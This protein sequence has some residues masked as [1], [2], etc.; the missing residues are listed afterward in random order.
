M[1]SACQTNTLKIRPMFRSRLIACLLL[2]VGFA[3]NAQPGEQLVKVV[4]APDHAD[5]TYKAGEKVTFTVTVL[6]FGNPVKNARIVYEYGPEKL[7]PVKKDSMTLSNG[8]TKI[9]AG[10]MKTAGFLRCIVTAR[11]DGRE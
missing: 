1:K 2:L 4:V 5:W 10:T 9:E 11:V 3:A 6:Q 8:S 7:D